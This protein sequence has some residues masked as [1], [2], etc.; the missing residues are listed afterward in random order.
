MKKFIVLA[1]VIGLVVSTASPLFAGGADNKTNWSVEYIRSLNRN[2]ATDSADIVMYNPAGVMKMDDGLYGN[3]SAHYIAKRYNN[4]INGSNF[5]QDEPSIVP[6]VFAVYKRDRWAGFFGLSNVV[7]GGKVEFDNGNLT[8]HQIAWDIGSGLN[9]AL[10]APPPIGFGTSL[11]NYTQ[12]TSQNFEGEQIGLGYTLGGAFKINDMFSVA[13]AARYVDTK[14]E[15]KGTATLNALVP[16]A[17]AGPAYAGL[18]DPVVAAADFE[19]DADGWG[20]LIGLN[21]SPNDQWNIGIRYET[22]VDLD[23]DLTVN[24][25]EISGNIINANYGGPLYN[26]ILPP[27]GRTEGQ[28]RTR[29]LPAILG[30]GVSYQVTP[31]LRLETDLTYYFNEDADFDDIRDTARDESAVDNGYD[32]G[33][34]VEYAI[35]DTV[36]GSF[37]YLY[38]DTGVDAEN[39]TPWLP[40]L[41]AH[42]FGTGIAWAVSPSLDLNFGLGKVF[43]QSDSFTT[44]D[45]LNNNAPVEVKYEKDITFLAFGLQ[46]KF[47]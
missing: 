21:I 15:M 2:A 3:V 41:N 33:I 1:C 44:S 28:E 20:G 22:K 9:Q 40:E 18:N 11:F 31:K 8:T 13:L 10:S 25:D 29:N 34:A 43:Y 17:A 12:V 35:S 7:G 42:S 47:M 4:E 26:Q 6:G 16:T 27:F 23:F 46:Y 24:Q 30:V 37:G 5:D 39:M 14:L 19:E 36:T 32:L 38:T 45:P